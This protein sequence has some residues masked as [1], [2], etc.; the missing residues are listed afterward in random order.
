MNERVGTA[1]VGLLRLGDLRLEALHVTGYDGP[2]QLHLGGEI[3]QKPA[4]GD[5]R[6]FGDRVE[7]DIVG[8]DLAHQFRGRLED[9]LARIRAPAALA[10]LVK[11]CFPVTSVMLLPSVDA[12]VRTV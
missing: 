10:V 7:R 12:T 1:G 6:P 3:I 8:A 5:A 9:A 11:S 2:Q 4:L